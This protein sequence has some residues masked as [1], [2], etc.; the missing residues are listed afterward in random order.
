[1]TRIH[2]ERAALY[3][4]NCNGI[5]EREVRAAIAAG[6]TRP[7]EVFRHKGCQAQCAKCVCEMRQMIDE[8]RQALAYAA[9]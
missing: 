8:S 5:R 1:M 3:I 2:R 6:A 9:E 7:A 4:C